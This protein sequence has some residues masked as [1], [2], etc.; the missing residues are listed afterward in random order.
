MINILQSHCFCRSSKDYIYVHMQMLADDI[1]SAFQTDDQHTLILKRL[2]FIEYVISFFHTFVKDTMYLKSDVK[3]LKMILSA[4]CKDS[5]S[6]HFQVLHDLQT[7]VNIQTSEF[8]V[9]NWF[10]SSSLWL[11]WMF[12][13][14]L[15]LFALQHF[16]VMS[17]QVFWKFNIKKT[18]EFMKTQQRWWYEIFVLA[19]QLK[20]WWVWWRYCNLRAV[21]DQIIDDCVRS[22]LSTKYYRI[23]VNCMHQIM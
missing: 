20:Y 21:N 4:K 15:W 9:K 2:D 19:F 14:Q 13:R 18:A 11:F 10:S 16:S 23:D 22:L 7:D 8:S 17:D 5:L 1:L 6:Q 12:Y 3:I